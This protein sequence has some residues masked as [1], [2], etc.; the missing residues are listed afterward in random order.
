E[1]LADGRGGPSPFESL[2]GKNDRMQKLYSL[3][4]AVAR[5]V[6]PVLIEGGFGTGKEL[7]A[8]SIHR[9][10][11]RRGRPFI[12]VHCSTLSDPVLAGELFGYVKGAFAGAL[13]SGVG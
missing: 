9:N 4:P 6:D 5:S 1:G 13:S 2:I 10:G 7:I 12:R 8:R 11:S 3:L